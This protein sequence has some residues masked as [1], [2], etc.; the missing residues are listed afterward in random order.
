MIHF[1]Q[2]S[3]QTESEPTVKWSEMLKRLQERFE[4]NKRMLACFLAL[5]AYSTSQVQE[6]QAQIETP[7][8]SIENVIDEIALRDPSFSA[9]TSGKIE[10]CK[11]LV[12]NQ[13][14]SGIV[15]RDTRCSVDA[16]EA[17]N[18]YEGTE[19]EDLPSSAENVLVESKVRLEDRSNGNFDRASF[20]ST[21]L[22]VK[23]AEGSNW[24]NISAELQGDGFAYQTEEAAKLSALR[25]AIQYVGVHVSSES[26]LTAINSSSDSSV[27]RKELVFT[28]TSTSASQELQ[29][30]TIELQ[31]AKDENGNVVGYMWSIEFTY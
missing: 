1:E 28:N 14:D 4:G 19:G 7:P 5:T 9:W 17:Q 29:S 31:E 12:E 27:E 24:Q 22:S 15:F 26:G 6:A 13:E 11:S 21:E 25:S 10:E 23:T 20:F 30:Y 16:N 3:N 18:V 8:P 2:P